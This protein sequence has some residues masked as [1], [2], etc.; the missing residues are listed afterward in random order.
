MTQHGFTLL[1]L[2]TV[3]LILGIVTVSSLSVIPEQDFQ[4][5]YEDTIN[6][7]TMLRKAVVGQHH[8]L[9]S[10]YVVDN[11][12]LPENL[13]DLVTSNLQSYSFIVPVF[14]AVTDGQSTA[15]G[16]A[17]NVT[18]VQFVV[19]F[20]KGYRG[21]YVVAHPATNEFLDGWGNG[22]GTANFGWLVS[23][24]ETP[25]VTLLVASRGK[26]NTDNEPDVAGYDMDIAMSD[27]LENDWKTDI[28]F[29]IDVTN[30]SGSAQT[31]IAVSLLVFENATT[32]GF[33]RRYTTANIATI[34]DGATTSVVFLNPAARVP[35]GRHLLLMVDS[36][37]NVVD[38]TDDSVYLNGARVVTK[39]LDLFPRTNPASVEIIIK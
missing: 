38:L 25:R 20:Q 11:G 28:G 24:S 17:L 15:G 14:D 39:T 16:T 2:V 7:T 37:A 36:N 30:N 12:I 1:E 33:W 22:A 4:L 3:I 9:L 5:H 21:R 35:I 26:D 29:N 32:T 27:I 23:A 13:E 10:G 8:H 19:P 18:D 34:A 31:D 6:R